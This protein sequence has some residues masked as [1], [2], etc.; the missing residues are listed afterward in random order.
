VVPRLGVSDGFWQGSRVW[1]GQVILGFLG[2]EVAGFGTQGR[3]CPSRLSFLSNKS[4][5]GW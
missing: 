3:G 5:G 2:S 1:E 4:N